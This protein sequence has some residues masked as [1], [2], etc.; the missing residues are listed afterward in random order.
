MGTLMLLELVSRV[1]TYAVEPLGR[2]K[3]N[4]NQTSMSKGSKKH[5][6]AIAWSITDPHIVFNICWKKKVFKK[7]TCRRYGTRFDSKFYLLK[8]N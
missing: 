5:V 4:S 3:P 1:N 2:P 6:N 8:L 7:V